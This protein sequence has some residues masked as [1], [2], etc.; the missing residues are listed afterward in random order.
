MIPQRV[1]PHG[2]N[3]TPPPFASMISSKAVDTATTQITGFI[4]AF[5]ESALPL[6]QKS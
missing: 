6:P 3:K 2:G 1:G 5:P 4:E